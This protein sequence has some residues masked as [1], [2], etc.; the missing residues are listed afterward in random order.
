MSGNEAAG[1]WKKTGIVWLAIV[2]GFFGVLEA[3]ARL[4]VSPAGLRI[5]EEGRGAIEAQGLPD[6]S[7]VMVF[8]PRL[9]WALKPG[10]RGYPV[11]G[12]IEG[13]PIAFSLSTNEAG[14][15]TPVL[16]PKSGRVRVLAMGDSATFGLG[17]DD[18]E[19]WPR[20]LQ[21]SLGEAFEVVN[22]GVPGYSTF[23]GLRYLREAGLALEP[24]VVT[25]EFWANDRATW[26]SKP[27]TETARDLDMAARETTLLHSRLY[28]G[29]KR[30]LAR[31]EPPPAPGRPRVA[32]DEFRGN[33][34]EIHRLCAERDVPAIFIVWPSRVQVEQ[35]QT[36]LSGYQKIVEDVAREAGA[37][38]V[39][40]APAFMEA[41][42]DCFVD[43]F[44]ANAAGCDIAAERV[45]PVVTG[46]GPHPSP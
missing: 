1:S 12:A 8:D 42:G 25:V 5:I 46:L 11:A 26:A 43:N 15:R 2:V 17:V 24:D 6:L 31:L 32:A 22:A 37:S 23:Q 29:V 44:H 9:F 19:T 27:D 41:P 39:D 30:V 28:V 45:A 18:D 34:T 33:L 10:L 38:V 35:R 4:T 40:L 14:L 36:Q 7:E 20:V 16:A 21:A 13:F 3:V